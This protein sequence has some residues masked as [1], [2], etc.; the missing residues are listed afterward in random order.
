[1]QV[2][3]AMD[4]FARRRSNRDCKDAMSDYGYSY[5]KATDKV[6]NHLTY[7]LYS[8]TCR[9]CTHTLKPRY[10]SHVHPLIAQTLIIV[11]SL[12]FIAYQ[13]PNATADSQ[14]LA[15]VVADIFRELPDDFTD[16]NFQYSFWNKELN[17]GSSG[18]MCRQ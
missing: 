14:A 18:V 7:L 13:S 8:G 6:H 1:M 4:C 3:M 12:S 17:Q 11:L 5:L 10:Q 15:S 2:T 16:P 9:I